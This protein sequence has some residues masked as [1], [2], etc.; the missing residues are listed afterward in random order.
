MGSNSSCS[1][2]VSSRDN[3]RKNNKQIERFA[4]AP[5]EI[6]LFGAIPSGGG[7]ERLAQIVAKQSLDEE[8][9]LNMMI[10]LFYKNISI[11]ILRPR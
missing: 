8:V 6:F 2:V 9:L 10:D 11:I 4:I 1:S 5:S 7:K 3:Q